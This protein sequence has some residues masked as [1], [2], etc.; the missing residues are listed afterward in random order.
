MSHGMS[1]DDLNYLKKVSSK[2]NK[3]CKLAEK[4]WAKCER[5]FVII[6]RMN[7]LNTKDN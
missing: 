2:S 3:I 6:Q 5:E 1:E 7:T 4:V